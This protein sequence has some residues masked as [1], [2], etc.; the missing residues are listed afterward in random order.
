MQGTHPIITL[1]CQ[2]NNVEIVVGQPQKEDYSSIP[3]PSSNAS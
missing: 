1:V 3:L 2:W